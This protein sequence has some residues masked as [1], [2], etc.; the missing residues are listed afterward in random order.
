[1]LV[2]PVCDWLTRR[3]ALDLPRYLLLRLAEDAAYGSGVITSAIRS[4]RPGVLVPYV[5]PPQSRP[6]P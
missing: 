1:M 2:P 4:R 5:R 6:N 3:P